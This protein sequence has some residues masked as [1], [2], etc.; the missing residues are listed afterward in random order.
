M[1][2]TVKFTSDKKTIEVPEGSN[3]R[4]EARKNGIELY[5]GPHR[6]FNCRGNG[7][8]CGCRVHVKKGRE[9]VSRRGFW[10]WLNTWIH[11]LGF[12]GRIGHEDEMRLAC[13]MK[14][15]GDCEIEARPELN[16]HGE[17]FW[18]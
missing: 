10:E 17:K 16:L 6:I 11:P 9:N 8:C 13:Q 4:R 15:Y 12:F 18:N 14:I 7:V 5:S 1:M 2:P 3:L